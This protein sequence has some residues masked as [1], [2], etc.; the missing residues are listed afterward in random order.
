M[1]VGADAHRRELAGRLHRLAPGAEYV[2]HLLDEVHELRA[3]H[4][5]GSVGDELGK[6]HVVGHGDGQVG[7]R[8]EP[9]AVGL[10][11]RKPVWP[12]A[13]A[14]VAAVDVAGGEQRLEHAAGAAVSEADR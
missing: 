3:R 4:G 2:A 13:F 12:T 1:G 8:T 6:S 5:V 9:L 11:V 14:G 10:E 7:D